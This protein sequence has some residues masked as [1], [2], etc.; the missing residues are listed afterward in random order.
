MTKLL[1]NESSSVN[2]LIHG[3]ELTLEFDFPKSWLVVVSYNQIP[4]AD[5]FK[6]KPFW[7]W[8]R[9]TFF[10]RKKGTFKSYI[11]HFSPKLEIRSFKSWSISPKKIVLPLKNNRVLLTN[12]IPRIKHIPYRGIQA[13]IGNFKHQVK[14]I[15][16]LAI[17]NVNLSFELKSMRYK[18][19]L[20]EAAYTNFKNSHPLFL[21]NQ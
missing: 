4:V 8:K 15:E 11:N 19:F 1:L 5:K 9:N 20:F 16:P 13:P 7:F 14:R 12:P 21:Q 6:T 17:K 3:Q 10:F 2:Y 18:R